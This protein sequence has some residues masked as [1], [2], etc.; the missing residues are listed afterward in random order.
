MIGQVS[1]VSSPISTP[2]PSPL[3]AAMQRADPLGLVRILGL[4]DEV[5]PLAMLQVLNQLHGKSTQEIQSL[6]QSSGLNHWLSSSANEK[7]LVS[8]LAQIAKSGRIA[9]AISFFSHWG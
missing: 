5:P 4:K 6:T 1:A 8:G 3:N 7:R 9:Q 2:T